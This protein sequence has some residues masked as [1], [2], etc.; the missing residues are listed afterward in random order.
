MNDYTKPQPPPVNEDSQSVWALVLADLEE[1]REDGYP[2]LDELLEDCRKRNADGIRKYGV[3]L[4]VH[5]KR[6]PAIDAYQEALDGMAYWKQEFERTA[7][8]AADLCYRAA[9]RLAKLARDYLYWRDG[10]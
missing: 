10:K 1:T 9:M 2:H 4:T 3:P 6:D 5:N 8:P 7:N